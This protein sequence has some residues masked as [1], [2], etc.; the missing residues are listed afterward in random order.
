M[1]DCSMYE[2]CILLHNIVPIIVVI[3]FDHRYIIT[4]SNMNPW[5]KDFRL[6]GCSRMKRAASTPHASALPHTH[7]QQ[8]GSHHGDSLYAAYV[9][10]QRIKNR[11][12]TLLGCLGS[13]CDAACMRSMVRLAASAG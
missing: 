11:W 10:D 6:L 13:T 8:F 5:T 12:G 4:Y 1:H 2:H 7:V 3:S 9:Q